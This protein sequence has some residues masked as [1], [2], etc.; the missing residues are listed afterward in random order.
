MTDQKNNDPNCIDPAGLKNI[1]LRGVVVADSKICKV[2][3]EKGKL[4]YRGYDSLELAENST[5]EEVAYLLTHDT[6]PSR[7]ELLSFK[8]Q[9][10]DASGLPGPLVDMLKSFPTGTGSMDVLQAAVSA[11]GAFDDDLHNESK[12]ATDRKAMRLIANISL[13]VSAWN[14][15]RE[16]K[17]VV[18]PNPDLGIAA[19]FLYTLH[20]E[21]PDPETA[22]DLDICL[23]LHAEHSFNA[24]TFTARQI[25]STRA[26]VYAC[27]S[28][29]IGSLSGPLHGG[30]NARVFQMLEEIGTINKVES[31]VKSQLDSGNVIMGMGHAVYKVLDPR[32]KILG[33]MSKRLGEKVGDPSLYEIT[34][35]V[36]E[37]AAAEFEA[38]KG[39]SINPN[40][41]FYSAS[42]YHYMGI[43]VDLFTPIFAISRVTGWLAHIIEEKFAEAAPKPLLYR[44]KAEYV[45]RYCGPEGCEWSPIDDRNEK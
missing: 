12:E 27:I 6:L 35:K 39:A 3:G 24:S 36:R 15:V 26:H 4:L 7:N 10:S 13:I 43:P 9:I 23:I 8:K 11:L 1:G 41:D 20:G 2:D 37:V 22:R 25:A 16:G 17:N 29:A 44:P 31:Y 34:E 19:N 30:A 14:R 40:V 42:V 18:E 33:P 28:G 45:G 5:F 38:R 21:S 32:A